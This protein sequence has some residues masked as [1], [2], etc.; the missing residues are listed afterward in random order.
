MRAVAI[1]TARRVELTVGQG[2]TMNAGPIGF[3]LVLVASCTV[4]R[5]GEDLVVGMLVGDVRVAT[6]TTVGVMGG[7]LQQRRVDE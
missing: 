3:G 1:G 2:Q 6:G 4:N 5:F 7:R